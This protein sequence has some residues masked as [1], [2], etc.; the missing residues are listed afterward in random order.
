M[1]PC[2]L[3]L[4]HSPLTSAAVWGGLG[5]RL[6]ASDLATVVVDVTADTAAPYAGRYVA[7]AAAQVA[8]SGLAG[9]AP[10]LLVAHSGAG[11][12]VGQIGFA[13]RAAHR[14]VAGYLFVD[15]GLPRPGGGASRLDLMHAESADLAA[16]LR[17]RLQAGGRFPTWT[18]A[19]LA[20]EVPHPGDRALLVASLRPRGLDFFDEPLPAPLDWPDAPAGV[21]QTSDGYE[22]SARLARG[23][24]WPVVAHPGGHFAALTDP[25][26]TAEAL[27]ELVHRL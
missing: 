12:L 13:L 25:A 8:S 22:L 7:Q 2:A 11:P 19:D 14:P 20:E 6:T 10:V 26:G 17:R 27:M 23:R 3:V 24:G 16:D 5:Q 1:T 15:A 18:D 4:L 9:S 21:L